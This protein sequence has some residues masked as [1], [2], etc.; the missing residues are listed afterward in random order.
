[1]AIP[2]RIHLVVPAWWVCSINGLP[3]MAPLSGE[4]ILYATN[5]LLFHS[6]LWIGGVI[7]FFE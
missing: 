7:G 6:V 1:M 3:S 2:S 4:G 5:A